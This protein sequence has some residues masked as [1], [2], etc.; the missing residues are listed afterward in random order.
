MKASVDAMFVSKSQ[1]AYYEQ[2]GNVSDYAKQKAEEKEHLYFTEIGARFAAKTVAKE[3]HAQGV[4]WAKDVSDAENVTAYA[5]KIPGTE[6]GTTYGMF[7]DG[8]E[9]NGLPTQVFAYVGL[10]KEASAENPVP[11]MVLVHGAAGHAYQDWVQFWNDKGY[12]AISFYWR[13]P[14]AKYDNTMP[15]GTALQYTAGPRRSDISDSVLKGEKENQ[16][17]FHATSNISLAY[18]L[19]NQMPEVQKGQIGL[20]GISWGGIISSRGMGEDVRFKFAMPI[21]GCGNLDIGIGSIRPTSIW[22]G[23]HTFQ[24]TVDAGM[25]VFWVNGSNDTFFSLNAM[26]KCVQE[27]NSDVLILLGSD[28]SQQH[29]AGMTGAMNEIFVFADY[30]LKGGQ[31]LPKL[32]RVNLAG[33]TA[34]FQV[35]AENGVEKA[36]LIYNKTGL[37]YESGKGVTEWE[38]SDITLKPGKNSVTVPG[39]AKGFYIELTD[40]KGLRKTTEYLEVK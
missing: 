15:D 8:M 21:Y 28:H 24:N 23:K 12:A 2:L 38:K 34:T 27:T 31:P 1:I 16:F 30:Y 26:S 18:N 22:D 7:M 3:L 11:A 6:S 37:V 32:S 19:L 17:M 29:G 9:Y 14:D 4:S 33:R 25:P 36:R 40:K 20:T 13:E 39:D 35:T 5:D 10:P